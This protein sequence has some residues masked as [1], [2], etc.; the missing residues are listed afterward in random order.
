MEVDSTV[1]FCRA[2]DREL[3]TYLAPVSI[4]FAIGSLSFTS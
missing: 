3:L 1:I 2:G 4:D